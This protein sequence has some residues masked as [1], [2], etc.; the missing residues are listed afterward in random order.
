MANTL[1]YLFYECCCRNWY[2]DKPPGTQLTAT[3][4]MHIT[5][6][7]SGGCDFDND[8]CRGQLTGGWYRT[9][10]LLSSK[11]ETNINDDP[12]PG[13]APLYDHTRPFTSSGM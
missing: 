7:S 13:Q 4:N 8:V 5:F 11:N 1:Q 9:L 10:G 12:L 3:I 6:T 2:L